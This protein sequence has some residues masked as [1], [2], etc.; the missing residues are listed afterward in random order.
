MAKPRR[1]HP[2]LGAIVESPQ[3]V[4]FL[5]LIK[6]ILG[7]EVSYAALER[8]RNGSHVFLMQGPQNQGFLVEAKERAED[9]EWVWE[10][11]FRCEPQGIA[12]LLH[13][14]FVAYRWDPWLHAEETGDSTLLNESIARRSA[15][16]NRL[17]AEIGP[18]KDRLQMWFLPREDAPD[19]IAGMPR[20][21]LEAIKKKHGVAERI[22]FTVAPEQEGNGHHNGA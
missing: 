21:E 17:N 3:G 6:W 13:L 10:T 22:H 4:M 2:S 18:R 9:D 12:T 5:N 14:E 16:R 8:T 1:K 20:A 19:A 15:T 11:G 7:E